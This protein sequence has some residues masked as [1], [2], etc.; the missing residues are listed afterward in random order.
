[1]AAKPWPPTVIV[2]S[3]KWM[4]ISD[5]RA[6]GSL[7]YVGDHWVGVP[8]SA[9]RLVGKDDSEAKGVLAALRSHRVMSCAESSCFISAAKYRPPGPPSHHSNTH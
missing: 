4:S 8:D 2:S 7:M 9:K 6:N 1:M 5:Q 3:R